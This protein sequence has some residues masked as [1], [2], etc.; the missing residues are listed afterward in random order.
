MNEVELDSGQLSKTRLRRCHKSLDSCGSTA[1]MSTLRC[2]QEHDSESE[3]SEE[4]NETSPAPSKPESSQ[5]GF[6]FA[7]PV[8][9]P[10]HVEKKVETVPPSTI[11]KEDEKPTTNDKTLPEVKPPLKVEIPTI[12][13]LSPPAIPLQISPTSTHVQKKQAT[14]IRASSSNFNSQPQASIF[15]GLGG[16]NASFGGLSAQGSFS[17]PKDVRNGGLIQ[18]VNTPGNHSSGIP[19]EHAKMGRRTGGLGASVSGFAPLNSSLAHSSTHTSSNSALHASSSSF[20]T[21]SHGLHASSQG[22]GGGSH[23]FGG[24]AGGGASF[25][26]GQTERPTASFGSLK[27]GGGSGNFGGLRGSGKSIPN[28]LNDPPAPKLDFNHIFGNEIARVRRD[29]LGKTLDYAVSS[30]LGKRKTM[31]DTFDVLI[32]KGGIGSSN[33]QHTWLPQPP[34]QS[35]VS[36]EGPV[37]GEKAITQIEEKAEY[38]Y[39]AVYDGHG[40]TQ[41]A[42]YVA[43]HLQSSIVNHADFTTDTTKAIREGFLE[44][45]IGFEKLSVDTKIHGGV[46]TTACVAIICG[47]TLHVANVG[48]SAAILCRRG[49]PLSLTNP[50][51]AKNPSEKKRV[52]AVGGVIKDGRLGHPIWNASL[53]NLG[54]TRAIGDFYFKQDEWTEGKAS[55]LS[56][57]PEITTIQLTT[58]DCFLLLASDGFWDVVSTQQAI[59]Y[60]LQQSLT[61]KDGLD[62]LCNQLID[63]ALK[64]AT[65]DNTTVLLIKLK[66]LEEVHPPGIEPG[67][68]AWKA[69]IIPLDHECCA[70]SP[71]SVVSIAIA[72]I[73]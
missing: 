72:L 4:E 7:A 30:T 57:E 39:F 3:E 27:E 28:S 70:G 62:N 38:A 26:L 55:G 47:H 61:Q 37:S 56:A 23:S 73:N 42:D 34:A 54:V 18:H 31:E 44:T 69:D 9:P 36:N 17:L 71:Q 65:E 25:S 40:G 20:N 19:R 43:R 66:E 49:D 41:A 11:S 16:M 63:L 52:E 68:P 8:A 1:D 14:G 48:D 46:G 45:E 24:L 59:N 50:H 29:S 67:S 32:R 35:A 15:G 58:D 60:I 12:P 22:L 2:L 33:L 10:K 6:H 51:T 64:K 5:A 13:K 21:S 53:I